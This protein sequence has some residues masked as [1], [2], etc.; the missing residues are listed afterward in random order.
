M[1]REEQGPNER[2]VRMRVVWGAIVMSHFVFVGVAVFMTRSMPEGITGGSEFPAS[3]GI[4][5]AVLGL[6][7]AGISMLL[8]NVLKGRAERSSDPSATRFQSLIIGLALTD[9][10]STLGLV[11]ALLTGGLGVAILLFACGF[12]AAIWH[13]PLEA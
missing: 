12:I 1:A 3:L 11:H 9:F 7:A 4:V 8:R 13:F 10:A 2:L 5:F 6:G